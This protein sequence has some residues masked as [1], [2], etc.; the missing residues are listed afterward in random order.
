MDLRACDPDVGREI[1][2][3]LRALSR[4]E[5]PAVAMDYSLAHPAGTRWYHLQASRVDQ[6]GQVVVTHTDV[7]ARVLAER[8]SA[9]Q[10]RH[11]PLTALPNRTALQ[12]LI[13]AEL[14]RPDRS[15]VTVLFLDVDGFKDV[16]DSLGHEVGDA[17]LRQLAG[18]LTAAAR[19]QDT[20]SRFG[21][22]RVRRPLPRHRPR[23]GRVPGP[24]V[25]QRL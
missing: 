18:R 3:S 7:T 21:G 15:P 1:V 16:N 14:Q 8:T 6:A 4:G 11:D 25:P 17:L 19:R 5:L 20:V 12:E 23:A 9:W 24:A 22:D 10:A 13:D 2:D